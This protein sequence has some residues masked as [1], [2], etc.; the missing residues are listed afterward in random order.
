M[1]KNQNKFDLIA[2][3]ADDTLWENNVL[4]L[5]AREKYKQILAGYQI[6]VS[7]EDFLEA[8]ENRNVKYYGYG[9]MSFVLSMV[10]TAI[11]MTDGR[12]AATDI[13]TIITIAR[14][15]ITA[16]IHLYEDAE[17]TLR[18]L[19]T[20]YPLILITKGDLNHQQA[21]IVQSGLEH[22]FNGTH[23][24]ADKT[25]Q[26]YAEILEK[27]SVSPSRFLMVGNSIRSDIYPVLK[28]GGWGG[29]VPND[30][31]W[32]HEM[33]ELPEGERGRFF[34]LARLGMLPDYLESLAKP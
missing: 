9:V 20:S 27:Y 8:T 32:V 10:E 25:P 3:D 33:S 17:P 31:T 13:Q 29:Y 22:Y 18:R 28:L 7:I 4:Y 15:M 1:K 34:E 16:E 6:T 30:F 24:V 2:F 21:K 14:E 12:I 19:S 26:T 11:E 23:I 5:Q